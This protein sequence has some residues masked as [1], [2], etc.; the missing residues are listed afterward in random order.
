VE[1]EDKNMENYSDEE[2]ISLHDMWLVL[3]KR[4]RLFWVS[5][6]TFIILGVVFTFS[7]TPQYEY[8]QIMSVARYM[9]DSGNLQLVEPLEAT[10]TR[11]SK[12]YLP[13]VLQE[14]NASHQA[15]PWYI[16]ENDLTVKPL[17]DSYLIISF[18]SDDKNLAK[19]SEVLRGVIQNITTD[20]GFLL[21]QRADSLQDRLSL[22]QK[23]EK[24]QEESKAILSQSYPDQD[25][26]VLSKPDFDNILNSINKGSSNEAVSGLIFFQKL[27][28][29]NQQHSI[30]MQKYSMMMQKQS[31]M[32][33]I[34]DKMVALKLQQ[35]SL[36]SQQNSLVETKA[37]SNL[38]RSSGAVT[39]PKQ[40]FM[41]LT[42]IISFMLSLFLVFIVEFFAKASNVKKV[43]NS[44]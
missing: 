21:K 1:L 10:S 23:Q 17:G 16:T 42:M 4:K 24:E 13:K 41:L 11:V 37:T 20:L 28:V 15:Q 40:F 7:T 8:T 25:L 32:M 22:L 5:F 34:N 31:M 18:R 27:A 19:Y 6:I 26:T 36:Q 33:Q 29:I 9:D 2:T 30:M 39:Q 43:I 38:V 35:K 3:A 44:K 12:V 14:Y